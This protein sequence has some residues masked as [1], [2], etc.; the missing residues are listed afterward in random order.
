MLCNSRIF[1]DGLAYLQYHQL[2]SINWNKLQQISEGAINTV[3][4]LII[5]IQGISLGSSSADSGTAAAAAAAAA[6]TASSL[7]MTNFGIPLTGSMS[8]MGFIIFILIYYG[9][10]IFT[11]HIIII[12]V[13]QIE[14][15][16]SLYLYY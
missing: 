12:I 6:A 15:L 11:V 5:Q 16:L 9:V 3:T 4:N 2:A 13:L 14:L 7:A 8:A 10:V 1:L